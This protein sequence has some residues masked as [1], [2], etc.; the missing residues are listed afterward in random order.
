MKSLAENARNMSVVVGV[1]IDRVLVAL[2]II[3]ALTLAG[4]ILSYATVP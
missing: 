1:H 2:M 4:S 3:G